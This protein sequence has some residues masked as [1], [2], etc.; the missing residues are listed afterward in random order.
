MNVDAAKHVATVKQFLDGLLPLIP[1]ENRGGVNDFEHFFNTEIAVRY[2][3][4]A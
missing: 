2:R 1:Q 3:D 4:V